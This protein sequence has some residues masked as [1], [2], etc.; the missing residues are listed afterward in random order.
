MFLV[1]EGKVPIDWAVAGGEWRSC[2]VVP[3]QLGQ[4]VWAG[5][6]LACADS[7]GS[8]CCGTNTVCPAR[9]SGSG[10]RWGAFAVRD[11]DKWGMKVS[12]VKEEQN[13]SDG[14]RKAIPGTSGVV[15]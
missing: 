11:A 3:P 10:R 13:R 1:G 9:Q 12:R 8:G 2:A 6:A 14:I 5:L 4:K 7:E 15:E